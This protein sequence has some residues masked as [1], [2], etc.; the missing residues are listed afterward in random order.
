MPE[1]ASSGVSPAE[2]DQ[3]LQAAMSGLTIPTPG[4]GSPAAI[5]DANSGTSGA[6]TSKY[7]PFMHTHP[8]KVRKGRA[9]VST[10]TYTWQYPTPFE[11]GTSPIV[12]AIAQVASG[13][14]LY[15]VQVVGAPTATQCVFQINRVSSGLLTLLLGALSIN[16]TPGNITLHMIAL[17]P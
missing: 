5:V 15:N 17:E 12:N 1:I 9:G 13:S 2:V 3:K 8:S 14:D 11:A 4:T 16:P 6:D 7:A 10:E